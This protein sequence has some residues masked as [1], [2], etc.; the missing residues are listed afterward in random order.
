[1]LELTSPAFDAGGEI[2]RRFT[3]D[4]DDVSPALAWSG[5]PDGTKSLALIVDDPDAPDPAAP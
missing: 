4:G 3:C 5:A 2:P 1:M